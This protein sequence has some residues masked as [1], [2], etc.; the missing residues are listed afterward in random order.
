[1]FLKAL[2]SLLT[3][4]FQLVSVF[5]FQGKKAES[6]SDVYAGISDALTALQAQRGDAEQYTLGLYSAESYPL[7]FDEDYTEIFANLKENSG[8]DFM[9]I[10]SFIPDYPKE[11][12]FLSSLAPWFTGALRS[13]ALQAAAFFEGRA[14]NAKNKTEAGFCES[15][16]K[17][18]GVVGGLVEFPISV[19]VRMD[20]TENHEMWFDL[21]YADGSVQSFPGGVYYNP[22][23]G[24]IGE[25]NAGI[26]GIGLNLDA[27]DAFVFLADSPWMDALGYC[28]LYDTLFLKTSNM[29]NIET[30]RIN[31]NYGGADWSLRLWKGRY[32]T[33]SGG[34]VGLYKKEP[35]QQIQF[36]DCAVKDRLQM[37]FKISAG[38]EVLVDRSA[39]SL[40]WQTGF[41]VRREVYKPEALTLESTILFPDTAMRAAAAAACKDA[42]V[43]V[44]LSQE[45][46]LLM[47]I[48][49]A[50]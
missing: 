16:A 39:S 49:W 11:G 20:S 42:D 19:H 36:Y 33:F 29:V 1:M 24:V 14:E 18:F 25:S 46:P 34:E 21:T 6:G 44:T 47:T 37:S 40:W 31:F 28:D 32:F 8:I 4:F 15:M 23:T 17:I 35:H 38:E 45:N 30:R 12:K 3:A 2:L 48:H 10:F 13:K 26:F 27:D 50:N 41:A 9:Q 7:T 43:C 22:E 5:A